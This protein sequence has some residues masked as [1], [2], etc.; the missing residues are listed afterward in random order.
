MH[1]PS[2]VLPGVRHNWARVRTAKCL[3]EAIVLVRWGAEA[4]TEM[5]SIGRCGTVMAPFPTSYKF[6]LS[7]LVLGA[8]LQ[9]RQLP[10]CPELQLWLLGD[11]IDLNTRVSELFVIE[12]APYWAF[13]WGGG[14]ALARYLMDR[15]ELVRGRVVADFGA[16]SGVAALAALR[17][18]AARAV[19]VDI[20]PSALAAAQAN[21]Q[22]NGLTLEVAESL[23]P[24]FDVLLASDVLYEPGN[25]DFLCSLSAA[26]KHVIVSDPLRACNPRLELEPRARFDVCTIPDVDYPVSSAVVYELMPYAFGAAGIRQIDG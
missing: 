14:Q 10:L 1:L 7:G 3:E 17:A 20:D 8:S 9:C 5:S 23:P 4:C 15:P 26:G 12:R 19:A 16:G 18:G 25:R 22:L 2:F 13:C 21:A 24:E 11:E 6:E